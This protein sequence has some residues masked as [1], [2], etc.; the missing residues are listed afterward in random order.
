METSLIFDY[1]ENVKGV[2][3]E[4]VIHV[5]DYIETHP[6]DNDQVL[7][8]Y[9]LYSVDFADTKGSMFI[10]TASASANIVLPADSAMMEELFPDH[11]VHTTSEQS[12]NTTNTPEP[13][14]NTDSN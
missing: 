9:S 11:V 14:E 10:Q 8:I 5:E 4:K 1:I 7:C 6:E 3:P 2:S 13:G 12:T